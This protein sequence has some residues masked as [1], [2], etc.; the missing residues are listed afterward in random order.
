MRQ[1][2]APGK[3]L[4]GATGSVVSPQNA[5]RRRINLFFELPGL[6]RQ[7]LVLEALSAQLEERGGRRAGKMAQRKRFAASRG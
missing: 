7:A 3:N 2:A 1:T 5:E 4:V 6:R